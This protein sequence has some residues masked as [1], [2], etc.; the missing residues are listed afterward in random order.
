MLKRTMAVTIAI[1]IAVAAGPVAAQTCT[2]G[3][4]GD[5]EGTASFVSPIVGEPFDIHVVMFIEGLVNGVGYTLTVDG[6]VDLFSAGASYGPASGGLNFPNDPNDPVFSGQ[7][8]GLGVCAIGF[9]GFPV[10]VATYSFIATSPDAATTFGVT[11]NPQS[12][13]LDT[14]L[15]VYSD[16]EGVI[17]TCEVGP[18]LT[19]EAP[20][21][22]E[23]ESFGAVKSLYR[24]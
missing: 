2:L 7:N 17:Q 5:A 20:V 18:S 21:D 15:P 23:S 4:Y 1:L 6:G 3:V 11:G 10:L 14:T 24:N 16:C 9:N 22:T 12:S 13:S 19:V 8:V